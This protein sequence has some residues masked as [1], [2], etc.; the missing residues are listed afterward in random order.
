MNSE[1][2]EVLETTLVQVKPHTFILYLT[3]FIQTGVEISLI[4][5]VTQIFD[6]FMSIL[7]VYF[8][9]SRYIRFVVT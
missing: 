8:Q 1:L 7:H 2:P 9:I 3:V 5:L 4:T 6:T